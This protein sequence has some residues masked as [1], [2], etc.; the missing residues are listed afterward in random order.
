MC[1]D[2]GSSLGN[3]NL[4]LMVGLDDRGAGSELCWWA[5]VLAI[6]SLQWNY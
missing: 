5:P 1:P 2:H 3:G 4:E 6:C